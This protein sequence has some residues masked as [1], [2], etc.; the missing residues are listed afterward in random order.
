M[1]ID[2]SFEKT[3]YWFVGTPHRWIAFDANV[4]IRR[5]SE[6]N[7]SNAS[8][9]SCKPGAH[10]NC[11]RGTELALCARTASV[12]SP[13]FFVEQNMF[14]RWVAGVLVC[15]A[16]AVVPAD[17][18]SAT[19]TPERMESVIR[20]YCTACHN[21]A[22]KTADVSFDAV[23]VSNVTAHADVLEKAVRKLLVGAMPP[24]GSPRPDQTTLDAL[25]VGLES[26]LDR[27]ATADGDPG[28]A[29]VRRLNRTEYANAIRDLIALDVDA[30][31][32]LPVDN[33]SY[34]FDN[35]ADVLGVTPVLMERYLVAAR[36][37]SALAVGYAAE[38]IPT[39]D[40]Y[41]VR[42]DLSQDQPIEGLPLGTRGGL[43]V[44]HAFPLDAEYTFK[45][46]LRQATLNN[47]VGLEHPHTVIITIDGVE[48][49][50][51]TIGGKDDLVMSYANSQQAA[52]T[53]EARL[54]TRL[55]VRAGVRTVGATFVAKSAS[56]R[57][58]LLQPFLRTTWDPVDYT[59]IPHIEAVVVTGPF[60]D[61]GPGDTPSRRRIF[62]C[63]PSG[64]ND[65]RCPRRILSRL[66]EQAYRRPLTAADVR[67]LDRFYELGVT[68]GGSFEAGVAMG[69]RRILAS[70]DFVLRV[71]RDPARAMPGAIRN[72]SDLE[73]ASRLSFFLWSSLP[74]ERLLRLARER[75]L[76]EPAVLEEQVRRM[77]A[78]PRARALVDNFAGQWLYLR[79]L[80][81][82]NP[83][84]D[85][86][87][88]FDHNLR[89]AMRREV[90]LLVDSIVREN[91]SVV[92]LMTARDTFVNERLAKHYGI[93]GVYGPHFRRITLAED[94]RRGLL[95]K[96][97]ILMVTSLATRTSPVIRGK[98]VL[99]N[100]IGTPPPPPPPN[101]PALDTTVGDHAPRS[102]RE[103]LETH[104][105]APACAACHRMMDP[106][107][108]ALEPFDAV[109]RWRRT[110]VGAP[111]DASAR[112]MDGTSVDG[113]GSLRDALI[114]TPDIFVTTM[115]EKLMVYAL[116]RGLEAKDLPHVRTVVRR[117][118]QREYRFSAIVLG[119]VNSVPFQKKR[120]A[121]IAADAR[122][123]R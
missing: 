115:T 84:P 110:D 37:I 43:L 73:L 16:C 91:R 58:G 86:F 35:I 46:D 40:T 57:P 48:V 96:G 38:I 24:I 23:D 72:I 39:A 59:G 108:F 56:L 6:R 14:E 76:R 9:G 41:R 22:R 36:R 5:A 78:D 118:S 90:E 45:I 67:T 52:E 44:T 28:R 75:R 85:T 27:A 109:G 88:D 13:L 26:A 20:Q 104:R 82:I 113:P 64:A 81:N 3:A 97:A 10:D 50:R 1:P 114:T 53:L 29:L 71:E 61:T 54:A 19:M 4:A 121:S 47:V 102:L 21:D 55:N 99:E 94:E 63:R 11:S 79:N 74:D 68:E 34:G 17:S 18:Q 25:R 112:L 15:G 8:S 117:A 119:I 31:A 92:D 77:L 49:H 42:P 51:A 95:G 103:R 98:W 89:G 65:H 12:S 60:N 122:A 32:L 87:P 70:P 120:I 101:V 123:V 66:A 105:R 111:I 30:S 93:G 2:H 83:E 33:S 100:L 7:C 80:R 116:G 69:L 107:G 62:S 106:I